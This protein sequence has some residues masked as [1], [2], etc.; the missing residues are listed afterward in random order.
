[1]VT[2][3]SP[4]ALASEQNQHFERLEHMLAAISEKIHIRTKPSRRLNNEPYLN[5]MHTD[6]S[7]QTLATCAMQAI[8]CASTVRAISISG[9]T[10]IAEDNPAF[11]F[12][13]GKKATM[14]DARPS[15]TVDQE[16]TTL[17]EYGAPL[18]ETKNKQVLEWIQ[19]AEGKRDLQPR[20]LH[21]HGR[22]LLRS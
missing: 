12:I 8:S 7:T 10:I 17:S 1:M 13:A 22:T 5:E 6:N 20:Q 2:V 4:I 19:E 11:D 9:R 18:N 16:P 14:A 15:I 21:L 3:H